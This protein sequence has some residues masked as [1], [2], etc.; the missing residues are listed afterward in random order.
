MEPV[1][2]H[3][4]KENDAGHQT[5]LWTALYD[6]EAAGED[7]L[8]LHR[9]E[10]VEVLSKD[11]KISGDEGW[12]TGKI[13]DKVGI[14][15]SNF[16]AQ[17]DTANVKS[18][19]ND[20]RPFEIKFSDL[21]LEEII[22]VGGFGKV[23]RGFWR[24][25]EVAVK[26]ARQDPDE[27]IS[28]TAENVRREA[29]LFWLLKHPNIVTLKG[30]CLDEPNF[31][32]VMEYA[33]GGSL[34]RVLNGRKIPP[35]VLVDWAIQ[36]ARGMNYLHCEAPATLIH[37]DLK[38]SN[39]LLNEPVGH[40]DLYNKTLKITDFG[41]AREV[42]KTTRMSAAGTYAWM[43]PEVI[44]SSTF[45]KS[46]DVWS[47]GV[48][49][50]ELLTGEIPYRGIDS[51]AVAYGVAVNKL[52]L[53]IPT[54]CPVPF[55]HLMKG[56]WNPDPH[57]R[58]P[59]INILKD[60]EEISRSSFMSTPQESFH[61]WQKKWKCEIEEMF[62]DL[63]CKEKELRCREEELRKALLQQKIQEELL[64][65]REQALH[66]RAI[67]LLERELNILILQQQQ[68]RPTPNKRKGKF[69]KSRL[70]LS[71]YGG[72]QISMPSDFRHNI[73]VQQTPAIHPESKGIQ[74]ISSP[75]SPPS[76]PNLL[77]LRVY[78]LPSDGLKGKTWGPS[79]VHQKERSHSQQRLLLDYSKR[80][81]KSAPNLE[82]SQIQIAMGIANVGAFVESGDGCYSNSSVSAV[83]HGGKIENE[84]PRRQSLPKRVVDSLLGNIGVLLGSVA[85]GF[86]IRLPKHSILHPRLSL[87]PS[88]ES[89]EVLRSFKETGAYGTAGIDYEYMSASG[90]SYN[91]YHGQNS[92]SRPRLN[93]EILQPGKRNDISDRSYIAGFKCSSDGSNSS[94][95]LSSAS[96]ESDVLY[97]SFTPQQSSER[98][99]ANFRKPELFSSHS[100]HHLTEFNSVTDS[101]HSSSAAQSGESF[102]FEK[103][104]KEKACA[105]WIPSPEIYAYDNPGSSPS[106]DSFS[107]TDIHKVSD[108]HNHYRTPS[109]VSV[110]SNTSSNVNLSFRIED[111]EK[112]DKAYVEN[113]TTPVVFSRLQS[114]NSPKASSE[115]PPERPTTLDVKVTHHLSLP[116]KQTLGLAVRKCQGF[117]VNSSNAL[118][119]AP[120]DIFDSDEESHR[121]SQVGLSADGYVNK[122]AGTDEETTLLDLPVEGQ[123]QDGTIPLSVIMKQ[124]LKHN[125]LHPLHWEKDFFT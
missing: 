78:A 95:K 46:S 2:S 73:T 72:Q 49:L 66:E 30:V 23:Y 123:S 101:S 92:R 60:L 33:R 17:I 90:S 118:K 8:T 91:T 11:A 106:A 93:L 44:K 14:F 75:D 32:L 119:S 37:R 51:L 35:D 102:L 42:Y 74:Y 22:G 117:F 48:L 116:K 38:S 29:K 13:S 99:L 7:E 84:S 25:Q 63:R 10:Q 89:A 9:G 47:Y 65:K 26:A 40:G 6:Y 98:V 67:D 77:H 83:H 94:R 112:N 69:K 54:T 122:A 61:S 56:C 15:P 41:L 58:P 64:R 100:T 110:N 114:E 103:C 21:E 5:A 18:V 97:N 105:S 57:N 113:P 76:S 53:P 55:S 115:T 88:E 120:N 71:K 19:G 39:V 70:K 24:C 1:H 28:V 52:T 4:Q 96:L 125:P 3:P 121:I 45:S 27:D 20:G 62:H 86:D 68:G 16:V 50:W 107:N 36:I 79:S 87:S 85:S 34:N 12:W 104:H 31:C 80:R 124:S 111:K 108:I 59:F 43:A 82:K 109:N 81:S